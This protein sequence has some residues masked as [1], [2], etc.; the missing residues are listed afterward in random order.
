VV[1]V[2]KSLVSYD[3]AALREEVARARA[4]QD[5]SE[6][7]YGHCISL[8]AAE[9]LAAEYRTHHNNVPFSGALADCP[10]MRTLF[11]SLQTEKASFRLLR[12]APG[13]AY[14]L[15]DD[16]DKG[17]D[18]LRFQIPILTN[19]DAFIVAQKEGVSLDGLAERVDEI[20]ESGDL[21]FDFARFTR[22][23]GRWFDLF[24]LA[25][26]SMYRFDTDQ[27]HTAINAGDRERIV[28]GID[29]VANDWVKDW[30]AREFA[31]PVPATPA[32]ALPDASWEWTSL[33]HGLITNP[34][35]AA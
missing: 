31:T 8:P 30:I 2:L 1:E 13:T 25:P 15:H 10:T 28:L 11:D 35:R 6:G 29:I 21:H 9:D 33:A 20:R 27:L 17:A 12:R 16:L 19:P 32:D 22:A 24:S 26:G 4:R 18:I 3:L 34:V 23:F 7:A 5:F 14:G